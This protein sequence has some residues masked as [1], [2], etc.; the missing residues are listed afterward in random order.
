MG[1]SLFL[2][3]PSLPTRNCVGCKYS[4]TFTIGLN[5]TDVNKKSRAGKRSDNWQ[6][7]HSTAEEHEVFILSEHIPCSQAWGGM[8]SKHS[9]ATQA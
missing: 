7:S 4:S 2:P 5:S 6:F 3:E 8:E 9:D 1:L